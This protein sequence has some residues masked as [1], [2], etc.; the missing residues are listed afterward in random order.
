MKIL[1]ACEFSGVVREAFRKKGHD[2]WSCDILDAE[3]NSPYHLKMDAVKALQE[4]DWDMLIAH[5]PC[6]Y[7]TVT[8]NKWF[9]PEYATRFPDRQ[10]N[11]VE[12]IEF[13]ME[14]AKTNISKVCIENPI[15]I[16]STNWKKPDQ[17]ISPHQFGHMEAKKTCL[18]LKN[19]P[20]LKATNIVEPEYTTYKSGK[21]MATWYAN[22]IK[23]PK[24]ERMK[25]RSKTFQ[26]IADAMADQWG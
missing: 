19:L 7:L 5:P 24:D 4:Q 6:T 1:I 15:G 25:V 17:I 21:R 3:D 26:G 11:R 9:K 10:K 14:F 12:A 16:M 23:L 22:A 13:F 18:W 20:L 8:G 2:A